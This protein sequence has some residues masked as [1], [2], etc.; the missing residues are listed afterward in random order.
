[1]LINA[2]NETLLINL[3]A[4]YQIIGNFTESKKIL[5][6]INIKYPQNVIADK[7]Y[8]S[9]NNYEKKDTHQKKMLE[10]LDSKIFQMKIEKYFYFQ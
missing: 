5:N 1:M 4:S 2:E 10:K 8:S 3:A 7:M 9:I 6:I